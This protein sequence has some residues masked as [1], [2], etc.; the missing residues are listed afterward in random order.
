MIRNLLRRTFKARE[1]TLLQAAAEAG[2][3]AGR[4]AAE[5]WLRVNWDHREAALAAI[6]SADASFWATVPA[7][8]PWTA[9]DHE[10]FP[11]PLEWAAA[12]ERYVT[13]HTV[14]FVAHV[15]MAAKQPAPES[16]GDTNAGGT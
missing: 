2:T 12:Q 11:D 9:L 15:T 4:E 1:E 14:S 8:A 13:A 10:R 6:E 16:L 3:R 7:P 5:G